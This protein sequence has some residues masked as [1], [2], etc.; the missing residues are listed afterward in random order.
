MLFGELFCNACSCLW[1]DCLLLRF[2]ACCAVFEVHW[3]V[4]VVSCMLSN[5]SCVLSVVGRLLHEAC[6]LFFVVVYL[7]NGLRSRSWTG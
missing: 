2:V 6:R 7:L 5:V 4:F 3:V 1:T